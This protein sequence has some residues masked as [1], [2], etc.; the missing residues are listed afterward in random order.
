LFFNVIPFGY[1]FWDDHFDGCAGNSQSPIDIKPS[2]TVYDPS[3][4]QFDR[5][6]FEVAPKGMTLKNNGHSLVMGLEDAYTISDPS[7]LPGDFKA[8]QFHFHWADNLMAGGSEH[9]VNG[10]R[11]FAEMHIVHM[12]QKYA[13]LEEALAERDGLAVLGFFIVI[14]GPNNKEFEH[15]FTHIRDGHVVY[16]DDEFV[17][18][19]AWPLSKL[20]PD[21]L[22]AYYRYSG[23]LT[24]PP[25]SEA[26]I[27]TVFEDVVTISQEQ[28]DFLMT[29]L[30]QH[31][32]GTAGNHPIAANYR[33][34][35][36]L[37]GRIV[38]KSVQ[39]QH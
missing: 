12:N 37:N 32:K 38:E 6:I 2:D 7:V 8:L 36:P 18:E 35:L 34:T 16:A 13:S 23:S 21:S 30:Y 10:M 15:M 20:M 9:T 19:E 1:N 31:H 17:Y 29:S 11:Y 24:T 14:G 4:G 3:L 27:W 22:E 33:P 28:A 39:H 5:S 25:C 26:V